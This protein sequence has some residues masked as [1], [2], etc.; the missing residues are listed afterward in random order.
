[1]LAASAASVCADVLDC[2]VDVDA[3]ADADVDTDG[4]ELGV[5]SA[6]GTRLTSSAC[7][8]GSVAEVSSGGE[9]SVDLSVLPD[10]LSDCVAATALDEATG[11]LEASE[12]SSSASRSS[13]GTASAR[14][15]ACDEDAVGGAAVSRIVFEPD[16][17][18][19][20]VLGRAASGS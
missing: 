5:G 3:D 12:P 20:V 7:I 6:D 10:P 4:E 9:S 18:G 8:K 15:F 17:E 13:S 1:M 2:A 14:A 11:A 19:F 16:C